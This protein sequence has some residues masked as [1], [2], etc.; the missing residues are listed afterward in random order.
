[1]VVI[2]A[3]GLASEILQLLTSEKYGYAEEDLFFFDNVTKEM[4]KLLYFKY[5]ILTSFEEVET[6]FKNISSDFCLGIGGKKNRISLVNKFESLGGKPRTIISEYANISPFGTNIGAGTV[7]L[8]NA[9]ITSNVSIGK[10]CLLYMNTSITHDVFIDDF[11]ELSPSVSISGRCRIG[12]GTFLGVG[13]NI[14]PDIKIGKNCLIGAGTVVTKDIPDK[15]V[16][17]GIP[18]EI[19]KIIE[20]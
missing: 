13:V 19:I 5:K 14:L 6:I 9:Q 3:G 15:S 12:K 17:V 8:G 16:V 7:I 2:G 18:G 1:M 10:Y 4:D 20:E 11:V